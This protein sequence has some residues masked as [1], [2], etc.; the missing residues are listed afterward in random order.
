MS[1]F[2][3]YNTFK[4]GISLVFEK[5]NQHDYFA[6]AGNQSRT[7]IITYRTRGRTLSYD[8]TLRYATPI[9]RSN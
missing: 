3:T 4:V 8:I 5:N 6:L 9:V 1:Y 7:S 2:I